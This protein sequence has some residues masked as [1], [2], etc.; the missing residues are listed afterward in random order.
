MSNFKDLTGQKIK[1]LKVLKRIGT[2]NRRNVVWLCQ[3]ECGNLKEYTTAMLHNKTV[4]SCGCLKK[5]NAKKLGKSKLSDRTRHGKRHTRLYNI[6]CGIKQRCYYKKNSHYKY[7]GG[8]GIKMCEEW[9]NDFVNFYEWAMNN[10]YN[11]KLTIDRINVNGNYEPNN[12]KWA[13]YKEQA[14]NKRQRS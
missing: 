7:Y 9:K 3:C 13:T 8:H 1:K 11:D 14:N 12:C 4:I 10:N 2:D 6:W 5:E